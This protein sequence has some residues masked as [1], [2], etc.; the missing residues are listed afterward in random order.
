[1]LAHPLRPARR[2]CRIL[3]IVASVVFLKN[4]MSVQ[5]AACTG[6]ALGGV[7]AYSQVKR[8]RGEQKKAAAAAAAGA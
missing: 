3:V 2:A 6:V 1:M 5:S 4:P 8:I 7:F